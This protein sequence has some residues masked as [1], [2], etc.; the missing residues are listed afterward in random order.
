[1][2]QLLLEGDWPSR[3]EYVAHL[4]GGGYTLRSASGVSG[5]DVR[6]G[7]LRPAGV[8]AALEHPAD[9]A[10]AA[11]VAQ[12]LGVDWLAWDCRGDAALAAYRAGA[13][14]VLPPEASPLD[15]ERAVATLTAEPEEEGRSVEA[16]PLSYRATN[17]IETGEDSVV[18]VLSGIVAMRSLQPDGSEVLM[19]LFGPGRPAGG[20]PGRPLPDRAGG[21][22]RRR[23]VRAVLEGT[24][25]S[26]LNSPASCGS[27]WCGRTAGQRCRGGCSWRAGLPAYFPW[28]RSVSAGPR[29]RGGICWMCG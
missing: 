21:P 12:G 13:V 8:A 23:G 11:N 1:M 2:T 26:R 19:G 9:A 28:W 7:R 5:E 3:P 29:D 24:F 16:E 17:V 4:V 6:Q 15:L 25:R 14:V 22:R 27:H 10:R 18:E 20:A